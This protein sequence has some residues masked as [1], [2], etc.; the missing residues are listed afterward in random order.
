LEEGRLSL[1]AVPCSTAS[2]K[3]GDYLLRRKGYLYI[4]EQSIKG[5]NNERAL[6]EKP[7][8]LNIK[9]R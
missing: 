4:A 8:I 6:L 5:L 7:N 9:L 3:N 1:L 2:G